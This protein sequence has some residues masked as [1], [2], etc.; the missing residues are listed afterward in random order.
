[1]RVHDLLGFDDLPTTS[2]LPSRRFR[3]RCTGN[4]QCRNLV[5]RSVHLGR[6][7]CV[8]RFTLELGVLHYNVQFQTRPPTN[9]FFGGTDI[10]FQVFW[11][12]GSMDTDFS[13][14]ISTSHTSSMFRTARP[15]F[16]LVFEV[17]LLQL[18]I[19]SILAVLR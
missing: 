3:T 2:D 9:Y 4:A 16:A 5:S 11:F 17:R 13:I 10:L 14:Q 12:S 7:D 18:W 1:M 6:H 8:S 15:L 19:V